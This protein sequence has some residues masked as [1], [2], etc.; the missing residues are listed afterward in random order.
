MLYRGY[1]KTPEAINRIQIMVFEYSTLALYERLIAN[2]GRQLELE[3]PGFGLWFFHSVV[4]RSVSRFDWKA[5]AGSML[6]SIPD[7][8]A[9]TQTM[10]N[11]ATPKAINNQLYLVISES[12]RH[13]QRIVEDDL[14]WRRAVVSA[15]AA[16]LKHG[17]LSVFNI[18]NLFELSPE[19]S[20]QLST[21]S[22]SSAELEPVVRQNAIVMIK[23]LQMH[24]EQN[25]VIPVFVGD[26]STPYTETDL[27]WENVVKENNILVAGALIV[28]RAI[29]VKLSYDIDRFLDVTQQEIKNE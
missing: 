25:A 18:Y 28:P 2:I 23:K 12:L 14:C 16:R 13:F 22:S 11:R 15:M 21:P 20:L 10:R 6:P 4:N 24:S 7:L 1:H 27:P 9:I 3:F 5:G 17:R 26:M 29:G 19:P 8:I